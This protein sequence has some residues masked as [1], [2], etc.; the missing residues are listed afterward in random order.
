MT[1]LDHRAEGT[2]SRRRLL[3]GGLVVAST[4]APSPPTTIAAHAIDAIP[5]IGRSSAAARRMSAITFNDGAEIFFKDW[6]NG[7]PI[8]FS[9]G[10]PLSAD[11]WDDQM[12]FMASRGFRCIAF[13][14]RGHGRSSQTWEGNDYDT[15]AHDLLTLI[16]ALDLKAATLVGHSAGAGDIARYVGT[17]SAARVS[18]I[19]LDVWSRNVV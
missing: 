11:V 4:L 2:S 13:D 17:Y 3:L 12:M 1:V 16:N 19:V 10:W 18:R 14:R 6:G 7:P 9:H 8:V 15:F 5:P